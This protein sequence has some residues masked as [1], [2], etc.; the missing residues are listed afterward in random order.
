MDAWTAF[1]APSTPTTR[2]LA[3]TLRLTSMKLHLRIFVALLSFVLGLTRRAAGAET[4]PTRGADADPARSADAAATTGTISGRVQNVATGQFLN[5]ARITVRG[6]DR[7]VFTDESG[8]YRLPSVPAGPVV[9][10]VFYTGLDPQD[11]T[12]VVAPGQ[13]TERNVDLTSGDRY[14]SN[15][16]TIKLDAFKVSSARET[17]GAAIA[18]N[19]Q[20]FAANLKNVIAA[21]AFGEVTTAMWASS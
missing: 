17:D 2:P 9:L 11:I 8:T 6:T 20:R 4:V 5:N 21:D 14:A 18:I 12:V 10:Q 1:F 3:P 15:D 19:E 16:G 7:V 13:L